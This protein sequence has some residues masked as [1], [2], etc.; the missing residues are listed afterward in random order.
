V[1]YSV[2]KKAIPKEILVKDSRCVENALEELVCNICT[3][4][5]AL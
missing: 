2:E 1:Q 5:G 4:T 3:Q